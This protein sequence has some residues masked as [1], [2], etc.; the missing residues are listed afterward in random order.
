MTIESVIFE[1]LL[2]DI[3]VSALVGDRIYPLERQQGSDLPAIT[4]GRGGGERLE[5]LDGKTGLAQ[6]SLQIE[7]YGLD[8]TPAKDLAEAV[9]R[10]LERWHDET[11]DPPVLDVFLEGDIDALHEDQIPDHLF[12]VVQ[13]WVI[14][15]RE[16]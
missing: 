7:C 1:R 10:S 9:R 12:S 15:Y 11:T 14:D 6:M 2:D 13:D 3:E 8:Y 5:A 4:Y 16:V